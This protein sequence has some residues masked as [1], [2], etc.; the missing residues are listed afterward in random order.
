MSMP[1]EWAYREP[2]GGFVRI[3]LLAV[4]L[5]L[6]SVSSAEGAFPGRNGQIAFGSG[7]GV[8]WLVDPIEGGGSPL[9]LSG[10]YDDRSASCISPYGRPS[11]LAYSPQWAPDGSQFAVG[12]EGVFGYPETTDCIDLVRADS[13]EPSCVPMAGASHPS[14]SPDGE[15]LVFRRDVGRQVW[16]AD[17]DGTNAELLHQPG[18]GYPEYLV[19]KWSPRGDRLVY[20]RGWIVDIHTGATVRQLGR[21]GFFD[22]SPDGRFILHSSWYREAADLTILAAKGKRRW[23]LKVAG[24]PL[25]AVWSPDGRKIAFGRSRVL[26]VGSDDSNTRQAVYSVWVV[27]V[28]RVK[29]TGRF[30]KRAPAQRIFE[31]EPYYTFDATASTIDWQPLAAQLQP[32]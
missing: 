20:G 1:C 12:R 16:L 26:P 7:L 24:N 23:R 21:T 4:S 25:R 2:M 18:V 13:W 9:C 3:F 11:F 27:K 22:W 29:R 14:F 31:T 28:R 8:I 19:P 10:S 15:R 17:V 6:L 32:E 30:V 5:T